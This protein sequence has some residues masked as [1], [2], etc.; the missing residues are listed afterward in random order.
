MKRIICHWTAG[1]YK[2]ST[3][4]KEHYHYIIEGDGTVVI[5]KFK[6]LDNMS[7]ADGK[8]AAHTLN[9]NQDSIGVSLACMAGAIEAPWS[10]GRYPMTAVQWSVMIKLVADLAKQYKIPVTD[11]TILSHAEVQSTLGIKQKGKWDYTRL[12]FDPSVRG[13][14]A[15]GDKLRKEVALTMEKI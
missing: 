1:S 12:A 2:A 9:C 3:E 14:K 8:Y 15:C 7:V 10:P 5:G 4:D 11:R 13:A 6:V